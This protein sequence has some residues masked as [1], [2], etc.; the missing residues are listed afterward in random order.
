VY[1]ADSG[2][3]RIR[4][5]TTGGVVTT[6]AGSGNPGYADGTGTAAAFYFPASLAVN[7]AGNVFVAD[8]GNNRIRE[9]Q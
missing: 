4:R 3:S 8:Y 2:N 1:V 6:V 7:S 9:I 5:I